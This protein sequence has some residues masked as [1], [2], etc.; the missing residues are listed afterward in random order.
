MIAAFLFDLDGLMLDTE[1]HG[2]RSWDLAGADVGWTVPDHVRLAMIGRPL[3][4]IQRLLREALPAEAPVEDLLERANHHYHALLDA[5]P[6][7]HRPGLLPLL[8]H[9]RAAQVPCAVATSSPRRQAERKLHGAGIA[10]YFRDLAAGDEVARGKPDPDIFLLAASRLGASPSACVALED[11]APGVRSAHAA[12][13]RCL[14]VPDLH[15]P[16]PETARLA[17]GVFPDLHAVLAWTGGQ[18]L[19]APGFTGASPQA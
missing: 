15:T 4:A 11:S 16:D 17:H 1:R 10:A 14:W 13:M 8:D 6:P 9:L 2:L 18:A 12:G 19:A 7:Q 5:E 3:P